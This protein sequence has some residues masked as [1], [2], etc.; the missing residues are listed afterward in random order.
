VSRLFEIQIPE[1][2]VRAGSSGSPPSQK[3]LI[4]D[5]DACRS[6]FDDKPAMIAA[7]A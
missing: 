1:L 5:D 2:S 4:A 7:S 3:R 6:K